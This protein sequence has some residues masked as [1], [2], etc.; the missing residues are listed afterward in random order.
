MTLNQILPFVSSVIML[1]FTLSVFQRYLVRRRLHFL[2]CT[3]T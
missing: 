2:F 1:I 3:P